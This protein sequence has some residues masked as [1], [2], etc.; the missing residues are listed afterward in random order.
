[1]DEQQDELIE[2][3]AKQKRQP[4]RYGCVPGRKTLRFCPPL[5]RDQDYDDSH[6]VF[7]SQDHC[8]IKKGAMAG[9]RVYPLSYRLV[10]D[11]QV[12]GTS[13]YGKLIS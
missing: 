11:R 5:S 12:T 9:R 7:C 13:G 6:A 2:G 8:G 4:S 1:M 10:H 3:E